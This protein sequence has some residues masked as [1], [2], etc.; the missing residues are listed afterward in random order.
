MMLSLQH[1]AV[2]AVHTLSISV[3]LQTGSRIACAPQGHLRLSRPEDGTKRDGD[4][5]AIIDQYGE[6]VGPRPHKRNSLKVEHNLDRSWEGRI[7]RVYLG[8]NLLPE[9]VNRQELPAILIDRNDLDGVWPSAL[10][11]CEFHFGH[12]SH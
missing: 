7:L 5:L 2:E 3:D 8:D 12:Q 1:I 11:W 10:C 6:A 4:H 9:P